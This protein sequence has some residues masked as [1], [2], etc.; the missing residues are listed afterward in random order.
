MICNVCRKSLSHSA[1]K[2][3]DAK[4]SEELLGDPHFGSVPLASNSGLNSRGRLSKLPGP[5]VGQEQP[6]ES[7]LKALLLGLSRAMGALAVWGYVVC[8]AHIVG[9]MASSHSTPFPLIFHANSG[10]ST[11]GT[12]NDFSLH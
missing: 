6:C 9:L 11:Q 8:V 4:L 5:N 7:L 2:L 1:S 12:F 3:L 10:F